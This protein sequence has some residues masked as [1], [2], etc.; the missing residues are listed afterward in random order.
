MLDLS[1]CAY[2]Q[3]KAKDFLLK[4]CPFGS[5]RKSAGR[6]SER[7]QEVLRKSRL[8]GVKTIRLSERSFLHDF[9][10]FSDPERKLSCARREISRVNSEEDM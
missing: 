6:F 2:W 8:L 7:N 9:S 10:D 1:C 3:A 5:S 4:K